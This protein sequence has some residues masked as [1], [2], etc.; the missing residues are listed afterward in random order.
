[1]TLIA[2]LDVSFDNTEDWK[3]N[4]RQQGKIIVRTLKQEK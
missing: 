1:M 3:G 2:G 4:G